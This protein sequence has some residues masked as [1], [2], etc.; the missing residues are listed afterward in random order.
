MCAQL[1][2]QPFDGDREGVFIDIFC[3]VGP[4]AVDQKAAAQGVSLIFHQQAQQLLLGFAQFHSG[5][6]CQKLHPLKVK[7][8]S[9]VPKD[10]VGSAVLLAQLGIDPRTQHRQGKGFGDVIV[11]TLFQSV[12][13]VHVGVVGGQQDD[14]AQRGGGLYFLYKIQAAAVWQIDVQQHQRR[15]AAQQ[16]FSC[17]L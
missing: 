11:C 8:K 17:N 12:Y 14:R 10:A 4:D 6:V 2:A 15:V 9:M 3:A 1:V 16:L 5:A 7:D 13:D